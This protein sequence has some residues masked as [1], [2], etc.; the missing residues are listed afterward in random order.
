VQTVCWKKDGDPL[1]VWNDKMTGGGNKP[2]YAWASPQT[3]PF[4]CQSTKGKATDTERPSKDN[5]L[6][7]YKPIK[8]IDLPPSWPPLRLPSG[9]ENPNLE[10]QLYRLLNATHHLLNLTKPPLALPVLR[11]PP[12]CSC[13]RESPIAR[14]CVMLL[15]TLPAQIPK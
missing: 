13:P 10:P 14:A 12:L 7:S 15:P 3:T 9:T 11:S 1:K 5:Y 4:P 6:D 2:H 8:D